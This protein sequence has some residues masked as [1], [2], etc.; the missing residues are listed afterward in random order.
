MSKLSLMLAMIIAV[1][2]CTNGT[3][4]SVTTASDEPVESSV[5]PPT[6]ILASEAP[7]TSLPADD[8]EVDACV[9]VDAVDAES[10]LGALATM[11]TAPAAGF[12]ATSICSWVTEDLALLVVSV[13]EGLQFYGGDVFPGG[14]S[15]DFG[16]DGYIA[17]EPNFGGVDIQVVK[18]TWV[19]SL[20]AAPFAIADVEG[21]PVAMTVIAQQ[22]I[23]RLP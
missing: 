10:V 15:L 14:E 19:V 17:I 9:L 21:L 5:A 8:I 6:T 13:F 18:D 11:D 3:G 16:D 1:A 23:D 7:T 2:A 22:A 12:G 4:T 20:S